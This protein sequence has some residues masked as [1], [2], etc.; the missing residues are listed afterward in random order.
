MRILVVGGGGR[1]HALCWKL[2]QSKELDKLYCAP[3]NAGIAEQAELLRIK[4]EDIE[5]IQKAVKELGIE[6]V[7][8]GPEAPLVLGI[9]DKLEAQGVLVFG[10]SQKASELEGSKVWCKELLKKYNIP[11]AWFQVFDERKKALDFIRSKGA[12]IVVKADGLAQGKGVIVA[13]TISE[14]ERAIEQIMVKKEFGSAGEK[15]VVEE[16]LEG[17]EASFIGISDGENFV[18]MATSQ[19]HKQ[20]YDDDKGPNTGGMGAY[21]PAP[22]V[23][24]GMFKEIIEKIML[25][26]IRAMKQ[27]GRE[28]R[29]ALYAGLMITKDGPKVLEFNCRFGDPETQPLLFRLKSDLLPFLVASATGR[30]KGMNFEWHQDASIC[31]VMASGGY[32]GSYQKGFEI[33]GVEEANQLERTYV[34]H[35]GTERKDGKLLTAGGRVLG[36]SARREDI[37]S[38]IEAVYLAVSLIKFEGAHYRKD[39]G[40]KALKHLGN[41]K[42]CR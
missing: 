2:A 7:V 14:A 37:A 6:L 24:E 38:A 42:G 22:V 33:R 28:Y 9:K 16:F 5:A 36:V 10:P 41:L 18:P 17:E 30:L 21:S 32:P 23:S 3:G 19:D 35:S 26:T 39:I 13:K 29:G 25:P 12:P 40:R 8:V 11:T 15:V 31:V 20:V 1:E 34:F 27:E 4:A